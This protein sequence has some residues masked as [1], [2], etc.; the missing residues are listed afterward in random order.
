MSSNNNVNI[1]F[2]NAM[3]GGAPVGA[4]PEEFQAWLDAQVAPVSAP[5]ASTQFN[6][7]LFV[8][9]TPP[10]PSEMVQRGT[11]NSLL[12]NARREAQEIGTGLNYLWVNKGEIP[13]MIS[14]YVQSNPNYLGDY[15]N[16]MMSPYNLKWQDFGNRSAGDIIKGIAEGAWSNPISAGID[17]ASLGAGRL[18][19]GALPWVKNATKVERGVNAVKS[20]IA[21]RG[22]KLYDKLNEANKLASETG[23]DMNKVVEALETG[24]TVSGKEKQVLKKM[25]EFSDDYDS[26]IRDYSPSTY[27]GA[28]RTAITQKILR[29]RMEV[30][31]STT[32]AQVERDITP[33]LERIEA[34]ELK[35]VQK[36]ARQGDVVAREVSGAKALFDKGRIKPI[37]HGLA[38]VDKSIGEVVQRVGGNTPEIFTRRVYGNAPYEEIVK[39][40]KKPE[41]FLEGV[42]TSNID[43]AISR[44]LLN[45]AVGGQTFQTTKL[46][47][48]VFLNR[49]LLERGDLKGALTE[50][51]KNKVLAD[52]IPVD[53]YFAKALKD[54][55]DV[56]GALH[57]LAKEGYQTGKGVLMA[58]GG[59]LGPNAITGAA[60]AIMNSKGFILNDIMDAIRS[61]GRISK[62][63]G[64]F[65][66]GNLPQ[67]TNIPGLRQIQQFNRMTGG[68]LFQRADRAIQNVFS[69]IAANAELRKRGVKFKDRVDWARDADKMKLGE[70]ITDVTRTALINSPNVPLPKALQDVAFLANPFWRW[71]AT[72]AQSSLR[73]LE[74]SPTLANTALVDIM[75]NIGFD[76]E[77]QNRLNLHVTQD[78]PYSTFRINPYTGQTEEVSAEFVPMMTTAKLA[79]PGADTFKISSPVISSIVNALGG[80]DKYG[81]PLT[82]PDQNGII[83][84]TIGT[85]RY[86]TNPNTG[87]LEEVQGGMA[88]EVVNA[89][90]K[91]L[92]GAPTLWNRTIGPL[93]SYFVGDGQFYQ[94]YGSSILGSFDR[95]PEGNALVGGDPLRG[96]SPQQVLEGFGG[97][98]GRNYYP[99]R[100]ERGMPLS[101]M[102]NRQFYRNLGRRD[103]RIRYG[104]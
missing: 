1:N 18:I 84:Q 94:P 67:Y 7:E 2:N 57:G 103:S 33:L 15:F 101:Q 34:G 4:S 83:T 76:K 65:R 23:A 80:V 88:D 100:E 69:E 3:L 54:Q 56:G 14:E 26:F 82:R 95:N 6:P 71:Q 38:N 45:G 36:L 93:A 90:I 99:T 77:M 68:G 11:Q 24:K 16:A 10:V 35:D 78:R 19:G 48:M 37:T 21:I 70:I 98:Y 28:E 30:N 50:L 43:K 27:T 89:A 97:I 102:T 12:D 13:G 61:N 25:A 86:R 47:D 9:T 29:D 96:R 31:P 8:N 72:A 87:R 85:K 44:D 104:N 79:F 91:D 41:E 51:R 20:E 46:K 5:N 17:A 40:L 63:L 73:M 22:T 62:N 42:I 59:Y 32:F 75:A 81:R 74:K 60:N 39:Q 92:I 49:E 53:K 58:A 66:R 52:D 55:R 64:T